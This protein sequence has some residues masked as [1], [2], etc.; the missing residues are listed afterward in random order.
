MPTETPLTDEI[1]ALTAYANTVTGASDTCLSDAVATLADG[2]GS[3]GGNVSVKTGTFTLA[4]DLPIAAGGTVLPVGLTEQPDMLFVWM[5][6]DSFNAIGTPAGGHWYAC[7][8]CKN[9]LDTLPPVRYNSTDTIQRIN[10][11]AWIEV[12]KYNI[13]T[14]TL[15][16]VSTIL[17]SAPYSAN[18]SNTN[19]PNIASDGT[20]TLARY[21]SAASY[22]Y[23]GTYH[24][25]AIKGATFPIF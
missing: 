18:A 21:S 14:I 9:T 10:T 3:G 2:Y 25:I 23:A 4:N 17:T 11:G 12:V 8:L 7:E 22:L 16:G 1:N 6:K 19:V 15:D 5:D 24:Y 13:N 20:V